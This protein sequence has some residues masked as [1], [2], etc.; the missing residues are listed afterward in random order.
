MLCRYW[1]KS[2]HTFLRHLRSLHPLKETPLPTI[3]M[4]PV[5]TALPLDLMGEVG[6]RFA[7]FAD[8][9]VG[10][11]KTWCQRLVDASKGAA[12][13]VHDLEVGLAIAVV[14]LRVSV[15]GVACAPACVF[16]V[17]GCCS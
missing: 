3:L 10:A 14:P 16:A 9:R 17:R 5:L 13:D 11:V 2:S 15:H 7:A 1:K 8:H 4:E 6:D 12:D